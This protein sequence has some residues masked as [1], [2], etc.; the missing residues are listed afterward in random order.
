LLSNP[1]FAEFS[2]QIGLVS[3]GASDEDI[4]KLSTLYW[5]TIEFGICKENGEMRAF[6]AALLSAYG[7]LEVEFK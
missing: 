6:G 7:E 2:Q 3:L 4:K 1:S 5:F